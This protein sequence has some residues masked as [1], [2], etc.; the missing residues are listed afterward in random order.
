MIRGRGDRPPDAFALQD[1]FRRVAPDP[2]VFEAIPLTDIRDLQMYPL[3]AA[4]WVGVLLGA[5]ALALSVSGLYGVLTY[6]LSQRRREIGIRMAL[7]AT[8]RAVMGLVIAQSMR[9]AAIGAGIGTII[10]IAS[11]MLLKAAIP[12]KTITLLAVVHFSPGSS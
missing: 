4:S 11:L 7:G 8:A 5:I 3:L 1:L 9:L 12:L 10:T 6:A 2:Q